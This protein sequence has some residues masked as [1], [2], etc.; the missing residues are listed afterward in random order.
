MRRNNNKIKA[1]YFTLSFGKSHRLVSLRKD[2]PCPPSVVRNVLALEGGLCHR[3]GQKHE[4]QKSLR[5]TQQ[6]KRDLCELLHLLRTP[7]IPQVTYQMIWSISDGF[8][9]WIG[10][11]F[12]DKGVY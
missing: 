8:G 7:E 10:N 11:C 3:Q 4:G 5:R 9:V 1:I 12:T 6:Y 2:I